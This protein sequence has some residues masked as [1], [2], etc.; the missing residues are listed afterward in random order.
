MSWS[1]AIFARG[2][3]IGEKPWLESAR[4]VCFGGQM[5]YG[6]GGAGEVL[7]GCLLGLLVGVY[8]SFLGSRQTGSEQTIGD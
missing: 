5:C 8:R 1:I 3:M 7:K 6:R 4:V 2:E